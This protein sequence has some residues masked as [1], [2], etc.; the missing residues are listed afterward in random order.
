M[1]EGTK[2]NLPCP[3]GSGKKYKNC[4]WNKHIVPKE[5]IEYFQKQFLKDKALKDM[6]IYINYVTPIIFNDKKVWALGGRVYYN[7]PPSET[8]HEF[9]IDILRI[10]L[11]KE[12]WDE[13]LTSQD[14][15]FIMKCF[16]KF[17]EWKEKVKI[18]ANKVGESLWM[19]VP[20]GWSKSLLCLAFDVCSLTHT[21]QLPEHLLKRIKNK[22][23]YQGVRYEIA[24]AAMFARLGCKIRF[25]DE[26]EKTKKHCE[27]IADHLQ[28]G[29]SIAV[30]VK[31]RH[32]GGIL[33]MLGVVNEQRLL[34]G[35][36]KRLINRA[37]KQ[38]P[39]DRPFMIFI[40][41]NSP[42]TP[43]IPMEEKQWFKDIQKM[44]KEYGASTPEKPDS[45][46]GIFFTNY[47]YHYQS[48]KE[49]DRGEVL[50]II[51]LFPKIALPGSDFLTMLLSALSN[52]GA[53][54][55]LDLDEF[56]SL[57]TPQNIS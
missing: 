13:Q 17:F 14:K 52:Y 12:W 28:T 56:S 4:C 15:H 41:I 50:H 45:Y 35:N 8:F 36:V 49:A 34:R 32:R 39:G 33:H 43:G 51:P 23:E 27:F 22:N 54:P 26:E 30:E 40:D 57:S 18:E 37:L 1:G 16:L 46:N 6:G 25:L 21:L 19:A 11:G 3:C 20:D 42:L 38:N 44:M 9:I 53:V 47:S 48:E 29:V 5:V 7:R 24:I 31:S 10:M 55:N 2:R